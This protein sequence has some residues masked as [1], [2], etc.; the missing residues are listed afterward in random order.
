MLQDLLLHPSSI[1][2]WP[3]RGLSLHRAAPSRHGA[4]QR[5][6]KLT[7][8][9]AGSLTLCFSPSFFPP[10]LGPAVRLGC[11]VLLLV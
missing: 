9:Q 8:P 10:L 5:Q 1:S 2:F 6:W 11:C 4:P 7:Q 3:G